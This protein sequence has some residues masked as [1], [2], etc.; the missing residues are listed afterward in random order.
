MSEGSSNPR[1]LKLRYPA[2]CAKCGLPLSAGAEAFW[3]RTTKEAYCVACAPDETQLITGV[4]GASAALEG[5]RRADKRVEEARRRYGD[6]AAAVAEAMASRDTAASWGKGSSGEARLAAFVGKEVGDAVI[7]FHDRLIPGTR[8]NIDHIFVAPVGI[9]VIDAKSYTGKVV[10]RPTGPFWRPDNKVFVG[11]RDRTK[12]VKGV[13]KQVEAVLAAVKG[14]PEIK[15][16]LV[17]GGLCFVDSEWGL[18]DFPFQVGNIWVLYPGALRKRLNKG[19]SL[20]RDRM[21]HIAHRLDLSLPPA[22]APRLR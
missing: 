12:L 9:W 6:H 7:S 4:P 17:Y 22:A 11:G 13:E 1:R 19:G 2:Q 3:N 21:D 8:G 5:A 18:T 14:D 15:G 16:T 20:S 10:Q